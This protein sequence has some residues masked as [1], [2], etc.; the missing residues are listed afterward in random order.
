MSNI[1][2]IAE[3]LGIAPSTVSRALKKPEMVSLDTRRKVLQVAQELGYLQKLRDNAAVVSGGGNRLI[4]VIAADLTNAFSNQIVKSVHNYLNEHNYSVVL[5][6]SYENSSAELK[7]LKQWASLQLSG[8]IV[9]PSAK[10]SSVATAS[11]LDIPVVFVDRNP[12][13][14][15]YGSVLEDNQ[16]GVRQGL[17][18]LHE[19]GHR[20]IVFLSGPKQIYTFSERCK[21]AVDCGLNPE[22]VELKAGS[23]EELFMG[24]FEQTNILMMR[25]AALKPTAIFGANNAISA[26]ILYALSLKGCKVPDDVS[27]VSYGDSSWCRFYPTPIT[28]IAQPVEEMGEM[29]AKMLLDQICAHT[30]PK[31]VCLK[32]MLMARASV[33]TPSAR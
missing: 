2:H 24:A 30:A 14:L 28:S 17:E 26:G 1:L 6:S 33:A 29:A 9:M 25:S 32:S 4:G 16:D 12:G 7:L 21:G 22:I 13:T 23:Y 27:V 20:K 8:L 11:C 15:P 5:G 10:F 31:Q 3:K 19:C 18:Y